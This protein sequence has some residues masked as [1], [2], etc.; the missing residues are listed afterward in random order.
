MYCK[1][2]SYGAN[3]RTYVELEKVYDYE[4]ILRITS[5][6]EKYATMN[7]KKYSKKVIYRIKSLMFYGRFAEAY[8][9]CNEALGKKI[10]SEEHTELIHYYIFMIFFYEKK[11]WACRHLL[12]YVKDF[13]D[14]PRIE[15]LG[16][17]YEGLI[18]S[19]DKDLYFKLFS[20]TKENFVT[21]VQKRRGDSFNID[22]NIIADAVVNNFYNTRTY[23][24][25][26]T[27]FRIFRCFNVGKSEYYTKTET[28][29]YIVVLSKVDSPKSLITAYMI[30][31]LNNLE[32]CDITGEVYSNIPNNKKSCV[33][34][35]PSVNRFRTRQAKKMK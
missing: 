7:T 1:Q 23:Y 25:N 13:E 3:K 27:E 12:K 18:Y 35:S 17:L 6:Y 28:C 34:E 15:K 5:D 22:I 9:L 31:Y 8:A 20:I 30:P 16:R 19:T 29:S 2:K 11:F 24:Q 10:L 26:M 33:V 14:K 4:E 21:H 32:C